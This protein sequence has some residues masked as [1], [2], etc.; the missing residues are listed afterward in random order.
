MKKSA[1]LY[2]VAI[3]ILSVGAWVA[4]DQYAIY[5]AEQVALE[6]ETEC[7]SC[8]LRHKSFSRTR[9]ILKKKKQNMIE[10]LESEEALA[11]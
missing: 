3:L 5:Q 10:M 9:E 7:D 6:T 2:T 11:Q 4:Y 8:T 1:K